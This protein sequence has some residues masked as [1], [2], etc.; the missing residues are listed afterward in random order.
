MNPLL[1]IVE[2]I[3]IA[4]SSFLSGLIMYLGIYAGYRLVGRDDINFE[5]PDLEDN[6]SNWM[7]LQKMSKRILLILGISFAIVF[8]V[9]LTFA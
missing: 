3:K 5:T 2:I 7:G 8:Y 6:F 9:L 1:L 4:F